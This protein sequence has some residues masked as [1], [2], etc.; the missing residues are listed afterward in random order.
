MGLSIVATLVR[1]VIL[2]CCLCGWL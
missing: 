1:K 2:V